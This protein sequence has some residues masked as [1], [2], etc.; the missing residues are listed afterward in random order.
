MRSE[1]A[2]PCIA[3]LRTARRIKRSSVP[4]KRS[5]RDSPVVIVVDSRQQHY[6]AWCRMSTTIEVRQNGKR[7][8]TQSF[9]NRLHVSCGDILHVHLRLT[10]LPH[11]KDNVANRLSKR[12]IWNDT[13]KPTRF[14]PRACGRSGRFVAGDSVAERLL[15]R[16]HFRDLGD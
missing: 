1:T 6:G 5:I 4:C 13:G 16:Q 7:M 11:E 2:Q 9:S 8:S 10:G 15:T 3:P 12:S 14:L